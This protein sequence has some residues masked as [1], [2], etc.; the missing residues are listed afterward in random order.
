MLQT[1]MVINVYVVNDMNTF[2][3]HS[4][5]SGSMQTAQ[6]A[7][8]QQKLSKN[9]ESEVLWLC[10]PVERKLRPTRSSTR[11]EAG[12]RLARLQGVIYLGLKVIKGLTIFVVLLAFPIA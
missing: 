7:L 2:S 12:L 8:S 10:P 11:R 5:V 4:Y 6:L 1:F 3:A 9:P